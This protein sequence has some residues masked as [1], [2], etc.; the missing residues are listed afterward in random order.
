[1][2]YPRKLFTIVIACLLLCGC[3]SYTRTPNG[4]IAVHGVL[5][6]VTGL[7]VTE[8]GKD[9]TTRTLS[10]DQLSGDAQMAKGVAEGVAEGLAKGAK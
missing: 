8:T 4:K 5:Q 1:M 10:I 6:K 2:N 3:V 9:G 7:K